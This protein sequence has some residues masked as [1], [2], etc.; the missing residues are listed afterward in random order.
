MCIRLGKV[1][2]VPGKSRKTVWKDTVLWKDTHCTNIPGTAPCDPRI[3]YHQGKCIVTSTGENVSL[4]SDVIIQQSA[5]E[6]AGCLFEL[7]R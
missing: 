7:S 3:E 2:M 5:D 1:E 4:N 6:K